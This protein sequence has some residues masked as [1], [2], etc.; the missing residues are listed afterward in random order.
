MKTVKTENLAAALRM[1]G[2]PT[3]LAIFDL[4]MQGVQCNCEVGDRLGLP[5]NLISHHLKVL[6]DAGL[7]NAERDPVDARWV[8][9][10][11]KQSTL[12]QLRDQMSAFLDPSRIQPRLP[13]CGP[14][15]IPVEA[16]RV[17]RH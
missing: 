8:Y 5:M 9:Y 6:R 3:R 13:S 4:L 12:N 7:V 17:S 11:I 10:S 16:L 14:Q 15:L 1:L 2:D